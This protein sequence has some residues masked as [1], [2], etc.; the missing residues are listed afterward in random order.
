LA[1]TSPT[2]GGCSVG[3]A[4][5]RT[6]ATK[7]GLVFIFIF[8]FIIIIIVFCQINLV[9]FHVAEEEE[10]SPGFGNYQ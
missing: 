5:S 7:F 4:C 1:L 10:D 8:I 6:Q 3:V 2:R 9:Q